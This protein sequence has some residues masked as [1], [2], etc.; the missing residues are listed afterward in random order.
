M[1]WHSRICSSYTTCWCD[2]CRPISSGNEAPTA[3]RDVDYTA[4]AGSIGGIL[5]PYAIRPVDISFCI[6]DLYGNF[7]STVEIAGPVYEVVRVSLIFNLMGQKEE[8]DTD[9]VRLLPSRR[10]NAFKTLPDWSL[11]TVT[12]NGG[13]LPT[14][15]DENASYQVSLLYTWDGNSALDLPR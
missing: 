4:Q 11:I 12:L 10:P 7:C 14:L 2:C 9:H 13:Y 3:R 15:Y 6:C 8:A 5:D 1:R